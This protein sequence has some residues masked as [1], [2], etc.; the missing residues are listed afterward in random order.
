METFWAILF[1]IG[2]IIVLIMII[3]ANYLNKK[4]LEGINNRESD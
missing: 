4:G 1:I 3:L 2:G